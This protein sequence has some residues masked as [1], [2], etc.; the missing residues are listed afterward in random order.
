MKNCMMHTPST[1]GLAF[2]YV[3]AQGQRSS[4]SSSSSLGEVDQ[5]EPMWFVEWA[6]QLS[7]VSSPT[8]SFL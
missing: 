8:T 6:D 3:G 4:F 7:S 2:G 1:D 5:M